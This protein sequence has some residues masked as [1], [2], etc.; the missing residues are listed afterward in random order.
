MQPTPLTAAAAHWSKNIHSTSGTPPASRARS[1]T[2]SY[3]QL[4]KRLPLLTATVAQNTTIN[5]ATTIVTNQPPDPTAAH[6]P[7]QIPP[8][9][10][11]Q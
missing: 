4:C 7:S 9:Q 6:P 2:P 1:A 5:L 11:Q 10:Q 3:S 8:P